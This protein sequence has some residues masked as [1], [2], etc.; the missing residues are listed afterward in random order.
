MTTQNIIS[1][2][3]NKK[4]QYKFRIISISLILILFVISYIFLAYGDRI[5]RFDTILSVLSG[6]EIQGASFTIATLRLPRLFIGLLAGFALG[7]AGNTFQTLL[8]NPLASPD[9]IG[10][11]SGSSAAAVYCILILQMSGVMVS[12]ISVISGLAI[13]CL[14]YLFSKGHGFSGGRMILIGLGI[15]A[16]LNAVI[17]Y[18]LLRANQQDVAG[19]FRWLSGSLTGMQME[20]VPILFFV[21]I[22]SITI[23]IL[24][25]RHLKIM[26]LGEDMAITLGVSTNKIRG[27]SIL[28]SVCLIAFTTSICGPIAFVAFLAG[29]IAKHLVGANS[30]RTIISGMVGAILVLLGDLAGQY[31]FQTR[32]PVGVMTGILGAPYLLYLLIRMNKTG[33]Y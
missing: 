2:Q 30:S 6:D 31:L 8:R 26:S 23:L 16:M 22:I 17:S 5:Y 10:V 4:A 29:P 12:I 19:A 15:Q 18:I 13:A 9:I 28:F 11:T 14:I 25:E 24:L 21:V 7:C 1:Y 20:N 27:L 33:G 32:F 3:N